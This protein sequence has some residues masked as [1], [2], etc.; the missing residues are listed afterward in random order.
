MYEQF[1]LIAIGFY[2]LYLAGI[3]Q[4]SENK[5]SRYFS[6]IFIFASLVFVLISFYSNVQVVGYQTNYE[7]GTISNTIELT[8][9][10]TT[11]I[12]QNTPILQNSAY[13]FMSLIFI[14]AFSFIFFIFR[15]LKM[16]K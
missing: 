7:Y 8:N 12:Y 4:R 5:F 13:I 14:Y 16:V 11:Y 1:F 6:V 10:T 3:L 2:L 15:A 9:T